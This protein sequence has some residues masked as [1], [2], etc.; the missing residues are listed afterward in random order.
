MLRIA[1]AV[2]SIVA[3]QNA[4]SGKDMLGHRVCVGGGCGLCL[5]L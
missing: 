4:H 3:I 5:T 2:T 1:D